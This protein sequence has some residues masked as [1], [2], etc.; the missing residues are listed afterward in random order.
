MITYLLSLSFSLSRVSCGY[1]AAI[2]VLPQKLF[3]GFDLVI[4]RCFEFI[5]HRHHHQTRHIP[6]DKNEG[7]IYS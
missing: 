1:V 4:C 7:G 3:G 2:L 5:G 6:H